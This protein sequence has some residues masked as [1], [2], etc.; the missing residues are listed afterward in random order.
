MEKVFPAPAEGDTTAVSDRST[1]EWVLVQPERRPLA[2]TKVDG[3]MNALTN[4]QAA[5]MDDPM[6]PMEQYGL[7]KAEKRVEVALADGTVFELRFGDLREESDGAQAGYYAM[8]SADRTIWVLREFKADQIF[9]EL[10]EL[11]PES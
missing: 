1:W 9:K 11:L 6:A 4:I 5:D 3:V 7:W 2:K 10:E 8:T